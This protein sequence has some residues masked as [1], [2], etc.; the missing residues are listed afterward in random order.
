MKR[1]ALMKPILEE[2]KM[3]LK[4]ICHTI[5]PRYPPGHN[6]EP[7]VILDLTKITKKKKKKKRLTS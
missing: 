1:F 6:V 4:T 5:Q 3:S 7:V 2:A